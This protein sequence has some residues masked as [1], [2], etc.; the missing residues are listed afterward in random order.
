MVDFHDP[1]VLGSN[2][3]VLMKID[4]AVSGLLIWEFVSNLDYELSVILGHRPYRWT[5]WIYFATR[6]ATL[7]AVIINLVAMNIA[8]P[9][10][11][12]VLI[13][14][15]FVFSYMTFSLASLLIVLRIIAIWNKN[16]RIVG[17][18]IGVW[19]ANAACL[20]YG[21]TQIRSEWIPVQSACRLPNVESNR[22]TMTAM[23]A[24]DFVL[25]LIMLVGLLGLRRRGGSTFD[26]GR[27]IWKQGVIYLLVATTT[28]LIPVVFIWLDLNDAFDM[29]FSMPGLVTMSI[30]A[31]RM[32]RSLAD[33]FFDDVR[34]CSDNPQKMGCTVPNFI[35]STSLTIPKNR[36]EVT[37]NRDTS[38]G[39]W[40]SP[41]QTDPYVSFMDIDGQL[42]DKPGLN[43]DDV[44]SSAAE[45]IST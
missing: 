28:E 12:Q 10:N 24:T 33:F 36:M 38:Y 16:K 22:S 45:L 6:F 26:L 19:V 7:M 8:I 14:F 21:I 44:E 1:N 18:A 29:M 27:L 23:F 40:Q 41:A 3:M 13:S 37:V 20:I 5:I 39:R 31:T 43:L 9:T 15:A 17:L 2:F 34:K 4:Y 30:A 11:C 42:G 35:W 32:Y 25:L